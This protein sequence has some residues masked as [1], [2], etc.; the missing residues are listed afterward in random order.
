MHNRIALAADDLIEINRRDAARRASARYAASLRAL[1]GELGLVPF[2]RLTADDRERIGGVLD[3]LATL[4]REME[5]E[6]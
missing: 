5:G 3:A 2:D 1:H 6:G 4:A